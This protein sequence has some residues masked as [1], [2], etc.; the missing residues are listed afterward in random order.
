LSWN[1]RKNL[2][3]YK[4]RLAWLKRGMYLCV[5]AI[6]YALYNLDHRGTPAKN[7]VC[8]CVCTYRYIYIRTVPHQHHPG[9]THGNNPKSITGPS[10]LKST[11]TS[12]SPGM[13]RSSRSPAESMW[14]LKRR[15]RPARTARVAWLRSLVCVCVHVCIVCTYKGLQELLV[16]PG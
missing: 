5:C 12:Y 13:C 11:K 4:T 3:P 8:V 15:K 1:W 2:A 16:W 6:M 10:E 14:V 7:I 9:G